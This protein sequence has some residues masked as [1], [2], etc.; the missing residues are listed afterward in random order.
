M[1]GNHAGQMSRAA[2]AGNDDLD[3][4]LFSTGGEFRHPDWR[5]VRRDD[6]PLVRDTEPLE[7]RHGVLH[8][9]PVGRG[10]HDD[11]DSRLGRFGH[12]ET[13]DLI[14]D[15]ATKN[16]KTTKKSFDTEARGN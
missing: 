1:R 8:R 13:G 16:T 4:A 15:S 3:A 12:L 5:S 11:R 7:H 2:R 6:M 9:L 14:N 10:P